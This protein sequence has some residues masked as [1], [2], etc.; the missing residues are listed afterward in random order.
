MNK[1]VE[2]NAKHSIEI[3]E[4]LS[5]ELGKHEQVTIDIEQHIHA[6]VYSR[7]AFVPAGIIIAGVEICIDTTLILSGNIDM[8]T[9]DG[10]VNFDGYNI[11]EAPAGRK[12]IF[13]A[14]TDTYITMIFKTDKTTFSDAENEFTNEARLLQTRTMTG[15]S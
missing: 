4:S 10:W 11:L 15:G 1:C 9:V 14:K 12:Q 5:K 13:S 8:L 3:A 2:L 7:T 6:G